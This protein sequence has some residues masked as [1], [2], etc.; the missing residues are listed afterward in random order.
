MGLLGDI[1]SAFSSSNKP[2]PRD[3]GIVNQA[4]EAYKK[5]TPEQKKI[6]KENSIFA[7]D[8]ED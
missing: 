7:K 8:W 5:M 3:K 6:V 2:N 1:L 4:H